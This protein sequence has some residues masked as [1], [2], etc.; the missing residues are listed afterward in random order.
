VTEERETEREVAI[1]Q[2]RQAI[3]ECATQVT[4]TLACLVAMDAAAKHPSAIQLTRATLYAKQV[5]ADLHANTRCLR[6][7]MDKLTPEQQP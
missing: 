3:R 1:R 7:F 2:Q 5:L 4:N 6:E